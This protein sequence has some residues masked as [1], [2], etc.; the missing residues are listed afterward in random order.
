[1][2]IGSIVPSP[3]CPTDGSKAVKPVV[4]I[5]SVVVLVVLLLLLP[6]M[7]CGKVPAKTV[8]D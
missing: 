6:R 2:S 1:M 7:V 4:V 3:G 5:W 8:T